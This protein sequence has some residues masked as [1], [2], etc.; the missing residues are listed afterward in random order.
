MLID[1]R[2]REARAATAGINLAKT[3]GQAVILWAICFFLLPTAFFVLEAAV[4]LERLR[5]TSHAWRAGGVLLFLVAGGINLTTAYFLAIVGQGTPLPV[6]CTRRLVIAG[7]YR[8]LRNPMATTSLLQGAAVGFYLGSPFVLL[9]VLS[10]AIFWQILV[11][12]WEERDLERRFG[13]AYRHYRAAVRCW[14]P[15]WRPY[16]PESP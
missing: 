3:A 16:A 4:G 9:Y 5:F 8:Y 6:A 15:R 12:P 11:R 13:P 7:P 14:V 10:G 1:P 2:G